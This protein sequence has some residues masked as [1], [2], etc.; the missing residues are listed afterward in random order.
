MITSKRLSIFILLSI[1]G[2]ECA[3]YMSSEFGETELFLTNRKANFTQAEALCK[4]SGA[5]LVEFYN[6]QEWDQVWIR[7]MKPSR[8]I[9]K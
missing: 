8:A 7:Y 3:H 4:E 9:Y 1:Q 6:E 5:A 2:S